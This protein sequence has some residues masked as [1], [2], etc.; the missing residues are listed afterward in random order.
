VISDIQQKVNITPLKDDVQ[1][2]TINAD[3]TNNTQVV[4]KQYGKAYG[5]DPDNW[6]FLT[7]PK[8]TREEISRAWAGAYNTGI[9]SIDDGQQMHG[10]V[11]HII[12]K[13][14]RYA[15]RF[16]GL[17]FG[18]VNTVLYISGLIDNAAT[19]HSHEDAPP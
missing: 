13:G 2:I 16:H 1:F 17:K 7:M 3:P 19:A 4:M 9:E 5:F 8:N 11:T 12:D 10:L 14:G 15:A 6:L 18:S